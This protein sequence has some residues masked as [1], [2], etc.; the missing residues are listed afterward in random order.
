[1]RNLE[2]ETVTVRLFHLVLVLPLLSD[3]LY[4]PS[5]QV[6]SSRTTPARC[7]ENLYG[8]LLHHRVHSPTLTFKGTMPRFW[9][10]RKPFLTS[11]ASPTL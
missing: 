3:G 2:E 7:G 11:M 10:G 1:M 8:R 9:L 5:I 4:L 6:R